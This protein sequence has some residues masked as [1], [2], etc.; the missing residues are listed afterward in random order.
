MGDA[1]PVVDLGTGRHAVQLSLGNT[2]TCAVLDNGT[3]KCWGA[4]SFG[5]AGTGDT[6]QRG[7]EPNEMG[8]NLPVVNLGAGRTVLR[9]GTSRPGF[10]T[11]A[12][13]DTGG[14]KAWGDNEYAQLGLGKKSL[15]VGV[16]PSDM[17]DNLPYLDLGF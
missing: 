17:G 15:D 1:L 13:T 9:V 12:Q 4:N 14:W 5:Q 3:L 7:D 16:T 11:T 10:N 6:V 8:D 2:D